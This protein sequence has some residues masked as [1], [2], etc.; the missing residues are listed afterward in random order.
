M[1]AKFSTNLVLVALLGTTGLASQKAEAAGFALKGQ[2]GT[3]LGNAFAGA[4]SAAEDPSYLFFNPASVGRL[5][6]IQSNFTATYISPTSKLKESSYSQP[7]NPAGSVV[8]GSTSFGDIGPGAAIPAIFAT[9]QLNDSLRLGL[10][11]TVPFGL[12]TEYDGDWVGRYHAVK[13]R[14]M[15]LNINPVIAYNPIPQASLAAGLVLQY[16]EAEL[17]NSVDFATVV[18][19]QGGGPFPAGSLDGFAQVDGNDVALG[20]T[21]GAIVEP[22]PGTQMGIGYRSKIDHDVDGDADFSVPAALA[23]SQIAAIFTDTG[24]SAALELP[25]MLNMGISQEIG[26]QLTLMVEAQWTQWSSFDELIFDFDNNV[27]NSVTNQDWNDQWF[28]AL[29]AT[30]RP[31]PQLAI[32]LGAAFDQK[33]VNAKTRTPRTPDNDRFWLAAG[34][35]YTPNDRVS[36]GLGYTRIFTEDS[37]VRLLATNV[38]NASRG[39]LNADYEGEI[40]MVAINATIRF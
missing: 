28:F 1:R 20:F 37:E 26:D 21:L 27:P 6:G 30:Y 17:S 35:D 25:A 8:T 14:L 7:L 38:G 10:G 11:I 16:A 15:T 39:D 19:A 13:S 2:S 34:I 5:D 24:V 33:A 18:T 3:A 36:F 40:D 32:R 29:G 31:I 4:S 12:G 22:T 9:A 23:G